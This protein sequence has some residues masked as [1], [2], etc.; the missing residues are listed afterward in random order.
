MVDHSRRTFLR[1]TGMAGAGL[2]FGTT[3]VSAASGK[4][5]F[6]IDLREV[7]RSAVSADTEIIHDLAD[8]DVLVAAGD[9]DEVGGPAATAPDVEIV[10]HDDEW[11]GDDGPAVERDDDDEETPGVPDR[12]T[13]QWDKHAQELAEEVHETTRGAGS[14]VAV[15]DSGVYA[16]H[17]DLDEVVN[18]EL[19]RNF[20][21]D[22]GGFFASGASDH[23]THVAGITAGTNDYD[24]ERGGI[25]GTAPRTDLLALRVFSP[26][27]EG[28]ATGD[29][30]AAIVYAAETN[31]DAANL[32]L[33]IPATDGNRNPELV[34]IQKLYGRAASYANEQ[35]TVVVNSAGN[36]AVDLDPE[37]TIGVPTEADGVFAVSA[38]GPI[39][40]IWDDEF[41]DEIEAEEALESENLRKPTTQPAKYT[42][43]GGSVVDV[44]AAGGNFDPDAQDEANDGD[45]DS[46]KWFYDLVLSTVYSEE[47][48]DVS[49]DYGFKAGTSMAAP[50]VTGA[51][52]LV[53]SLRP[54][55]SV[56]AVEDLLRDTARDIG[57]ADYRGDGHL[58]LTALIGAASG[59]GGDDEDDDGDEDDGEEDG[60]D[61]DD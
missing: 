24:G 12:R 7:D 50:Q 17:P 56:A 61:E 14:R 13:L 22:G 2:A 29:I 38:T 49:P 37:E 46:P 34:A 10:P 58:D 53:R 32:S 51:V 43:Y 39:G 23:G 44:S 18:E 47:N 21:G 9:P 20:T 54:E 42:T 28:A 4:K 31:C 35:G 11:D 36:S 15:I 59:E 41:D 6:L 3:A 48:G 5:R 30:L 27:N 60:E 55:M 40:Y 52:A 8:I 25:L 26:G 16:D 57:E 1:L 33:G 19:S 45:A